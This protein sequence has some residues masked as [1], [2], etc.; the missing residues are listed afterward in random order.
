MAAV[1]GFAD[2]AAGTC[3]RDGA[4][5]CGFA[6]ALGAG[7]AGAGSAGGAAAGAV[8]RGGGRL[9]GWPRLLWARAGGASRRRSA[10][11][12]AREERV[13]TPPCQAEATPVKQAHHDRR[14]ER[15]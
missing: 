11:S 10:G 13:T 12:A 3:G 7:T 4:V 14:V 5:A 15:P 9:P 1:S 6:G 2:G 8:A